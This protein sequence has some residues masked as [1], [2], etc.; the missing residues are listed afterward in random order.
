LVPVMF[1]LLAKKEEPVPSITDVVASE[2]P[3]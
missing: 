3:A 1:M 2:V